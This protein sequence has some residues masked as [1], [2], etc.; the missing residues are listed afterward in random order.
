[1]QTSAFGLA[2]PEGC[3]EPQ[4]VQVYC[5]FTGELSPAKPFPNKSLGMNF[6]CLI[7]TCPA[8]FPSLEAYVVL[9]Y[10]HGAGRRWF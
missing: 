4:G 8:V 7:I 5:E 6:L 10:K 1:M 9:L 2:V 3:A